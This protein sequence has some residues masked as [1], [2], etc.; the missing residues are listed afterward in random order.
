MPHKIMTYL[1]FGFVSAVALT[2]PVQRASANALTLRTDGIDY[3]AGDTVN[4]TG[5]GFWPNETVRVQVTPQS[6]SGSGTAYVPWTIA[7][8]GG[9]LFQTSWSIP[10]E[11]SLDQVFVMSATGE[12]SGLSTTTT[13][14]SG[15][16]KLRFVTDG[17][18]SVCAGKNIAVCATLTERC[19]EDARAPL[20][21][22]MVLFFIGEG[23][24]G[25]SIGQQAD[26][27]A[28]T[29]ANGVACANLTLPNA[30]GP[31]SIRIKYRGENKP[32]QYTPPNS[33]CEPGERERLSGS[34]DCRTLA[35]TDCRRKVSGLLAVDNVVG[36]FVGDTGTFTFYI[37]L[38][39]SSSN[40][41][42]LFGFVNSF[43]ISSPDGAIL[44]GTKGAVS[45]TLSQS[46]SSVNFSATG[47]GSAPDTVTLRTSGFAANP[48]PPGDYEAAFAFGLLLHRSDTGKTICIDSV[49]DSPVFPWLWVSP[50]PADT[51]TPVWGGRFCYTVKFD[52]VFTSS[53]QY[54]A[55]IMFLKASDLDQ[56]NFT[57]IVYSTS[58]TASPALGGLWVAYGRPD[59][60]FDAPIR[61]LGARRTPM[62]V[63]FVNADTLADIV[64][65]GGV[66]GK[67]IY[68][69]LNQGDRTFSVDSTPYGGGIVNSIVAGHFNSDPFLDIAL[70]DGTILYGHGGGFTT[71]ALLTL[72]AEGLNVADFNRD[73]HDDLAVSQND[74]VTIYLNDGAGGFNRTSAIFVG[75]NVSPIPP[76]RAVADLDKDGIPD[77]ASVVYLGANPVPRSLVTVGFGDGAGGFKRAYD[78]TLNGFAVNVEIA[79]VDRD[80]NLDVIS[81]CGSNPE[82]RVIVLYGDG[83]GNFPRVSESL[84]PSSAGSTLAI[85]TADL[86]RDGNPDFVSGAYQGPG[87]VTIMYST[88]PDAKVLADEMVVTGYSGIHGGGTSQR[89]PQSGDGQVSIKVINPDDYVIAENNSTVSGSF[90][91]KLD[92]DQNAI[93]DE[94]TVDYNLQEGE[95][96]IVVH[97]E[98]NVGDPTFSVGVGIDGSQQ[99][100]LALNNGELGSFF[101]RASSSGNSVDSVVLYYR[102]EAI[103]AISPESGVP[104]TNSQPIMNW[105]GLLR[106]TTATQTFDFQLSNYTDF[107][108]YIENVSGLSAPQHMLNEVLDRNA[109]YYW[110]VRVEDNGQPGPW[111]H[112][113]AL[114]VTSGCCSGYTGNVDCDPE[115]RV[116]ISDL[117]RLVDYMYVTLAPLCCVDEANIDGLDGV[118]AADLIGLLNYLYFPSAAPPIPCKN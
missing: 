36:R 94:R 18:D 66:D 117:T 3:A 82:Q 10:I 90:V 91:W 64:A 57:D 87:P 19:D 116:D 54:S 89:S 103:P 105:G 118:D 72:A 110:R 101:G 80:H 38:I 67:F 115:N 1:L 102:V 95:Y 22:R 23:Q 88:P 69:L 46:F 13:F 71:Q 59:G 104:T 31:Y 92:A 75:H 44:G 96:T 108:S 43:V 49:G 68:T 48:L 50:T 14:M 21:N 20:P 11:D 113:Y 28:Y 41:D 51:V 12:I 79:D 26:D 84:Y 98:P 16:T 35:V 107:R 100:T 112:H 77:I 6:S 109:V 53:Q 73:G 42:S 9:G 93:L 27:S 45:A 8:D 74:S 17:L 25:V 111:S 24:C 76:S 62:V 58:G 56:D 40:P 86:D 65:V 99:A 34:N 78:T 4:A 60:T 37:R 29:D 114:F 61:L 55:D 63:D 52:T 106:R 32:D 70:G 30:P 5:G 15:N 81:S 33:A 2:S 7:V 97:P 85:T 39:Q 47:G 83:H